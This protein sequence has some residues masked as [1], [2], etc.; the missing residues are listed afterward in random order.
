MLLYAIVFEDVMTFRFLYAILM[1]L[2][3]TLLIFLTYNFAQ[4]Q[5][6]CSM[7]GFEY[8]LRGGE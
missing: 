1:M 5:M 6:F 8:K 4:D 7:A 3:I 2:Y